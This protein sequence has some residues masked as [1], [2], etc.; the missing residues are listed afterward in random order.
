MRKSRS[1]TRA[2]LSP[3]ARRSGLAAIALVAIGAAIAAN[4][5]YWQNGTH[6]APLF[7]TRGVRAAPGPAPLPRTA[8]RSAREVPAGAPA[9]TF[10][11][12][13]PA[14]DVV[15]AAVQAGLAGAGFYDGPLD[16]IDGPQTRAAVLR[17]QRT[18]GL[19]ETGSAT[20][21]LLAALEEGSGD[22]S[23]GDAKVLLVQRALAAAAYGPLA[24]DGV[25]GAETSDAI[26]RFQ[27]E[28][29]M[30]ATG[31]IDDVLIRRLAAVGAIDAL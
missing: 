31:E 25:F 8:P 29:G 28:H 21:D 19:P 23:G 22:G 10:E 6:P 14:G 18:H 11:T 26:R 30:A 5:L 9:G 15:V 17:Y 4:A 24:V 13:V 7:A 3:L 27:L 16:G 20:A 2:V 1:K 12:S